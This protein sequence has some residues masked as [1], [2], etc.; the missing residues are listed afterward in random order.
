MASRYAPIRIDLSG[1]DTPIDGI[2]RVTQR[3]GAIDQNPDVVTV[4]LVHG[5]LDNGTYAGTIPIFDPLNPIDV[6][7]LSS[8][9][10][11]IVEQSTNVRLFQ[12]TARSL[13]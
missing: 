11:L 5:T 12:R 4:D 10:R 6:A 3:I 9:G 1:V 13:L 8:D 2:L 7:V